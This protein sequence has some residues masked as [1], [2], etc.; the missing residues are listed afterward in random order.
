VGGCT[1]DDA[2]S[3]AIDQGEI[4]PSYDHCNSI[5][6]GDDLCLVADTCS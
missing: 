2:C 4:D 1:S 6:E 5:A 3:D